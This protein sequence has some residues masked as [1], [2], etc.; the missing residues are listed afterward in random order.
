M[1]YMS[2]LS[3][4]L[5]RILK[6]QTRMEIQNNGSQMLFCRL[7][8]GW[9]HKITWD[10]HYINLSPFFQ[11]EILYQKEVDCQGAC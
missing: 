1:C 10:I 6:R 5:K 7:E 4:F 11:H 9:F 2:I 8:L 3:Q